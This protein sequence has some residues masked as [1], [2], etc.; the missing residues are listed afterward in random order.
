MSSCSLRSRGCTCAASFNTLST[1]SCE[2][3][4]VYMEKKIRNANLDLFSV[5]VKYSLSHSLILFVLPGTEGH[6]KVHQHFLKWNSL[7]KFMLPLPGCHKNMQKPYSL[8]KFMISD[9]CTII[10]K[11]LTDREM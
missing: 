8:A 5:H 4:Y 11:L 2:V 10:S 9:N 3:N 6:I 7:V 1:A